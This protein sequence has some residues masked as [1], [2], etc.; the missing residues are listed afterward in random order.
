M[1]ETKLTNKRE[2]VETWFV[3]CVL[4]QNKLKT[5]DMWIL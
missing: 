1:A 4:M 5:S 3:K 2:S